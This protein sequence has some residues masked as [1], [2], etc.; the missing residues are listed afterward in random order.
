VTLTSDIRQI[1]LVHRG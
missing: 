1:N